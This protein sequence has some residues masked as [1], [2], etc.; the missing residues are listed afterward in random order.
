MNDPATHERK[1]EAQ[2]RWR[3][4]NRASRLEAQRERYRRNLER[5]RALAR[6]RMQ[7]ANH[8]LTPADKAL[9]L[10]QQD[11]RCYLCGDEITLE[12]AVI[13]HDHRCHKRRS[14]Q[15]CQRGLSCAP[16]NMVLGAASD[17]PAR[18]RRIADSLEIALALTAERMMQK[19]EQ[20]S[21]IQ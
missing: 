11:G 14:C 18:L 12:T 1:L 3:I 17:D 13:E 7:K 8:G 9:I 19:P 16:C 21:L 6:A 2:Q 4:K 5:E 20:P 10:Q 15:Y